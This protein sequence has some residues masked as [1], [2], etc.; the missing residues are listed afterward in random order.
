MKKLLVG[1]VLVLTLAGCSSN[2]SGS[3]AIKV[4]S[5]DESSGTRLAFE[6][7]VGIESLTNEAAIATANGDL[8]TQVGG[9]VDAIGYVS[10][11]TDFE[12][13]NIKP[14]K[15]EG[16]DATVATVN[17]GSYQLARPFGYVTRAKGDFESDK[18]EA[19]V[20]AFLDY[21]ENSKEGRQVVLAAGGVADVDAGTP[22]S[23]LKKNHP[24]VD[25]D[26]SDITIKT[27]GSTSVT[28]TLTQGL[29]SFK[30]LA[31]GF[32]FQMNHGGSGDAHKRTIGSEKTSANAI[33]IGFVSRDFK[34]DGSEDLKASMLNGVYCKD[35]VVVVVSKTNKTEA[36]SK[37]ATKEIFE[38]KLTTWDQ[39]K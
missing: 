1:L 18:K 15:Y 22:W 4:Y 16:V 9:N 24:I 27:G 26:N 23:E 11:S 14:L 12:K 2:G 3:K 37:A 32:N 35:A 36:I 6:E 38:G 19:L 17:D 5:R 10:L 33:D 20:I 13:N 7:I 34:T 39:V 30:T 25:Q 8:A 28:K 31:G 29:E 21:L